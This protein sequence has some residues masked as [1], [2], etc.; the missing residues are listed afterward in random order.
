MHAAMLPRSNTRH[1]SGTR[2]AVHTL[3]AASNPLSGACRLRTGTHRGSTASRPS[4]KEAP[5]AAPTASEGTL[6]RQAS[7]GG[8]RTP[9]AAASP[10]AL[11][12][13]GGGNARAHQ[14]SASCAREQ[15][16]S[17]AMG[18][19]ASTLSRFAWTSFFSRRPLYISSAR[20]LRRTRAHAAVSRSPKC[21]RT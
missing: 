8:A 18:F 20:R 9:R 3:R 16:R 2:A 1:S 11:R 17:C 4:P 10:G 12:Q 14:A 5:Q 6:G 13:G 21:G 7:L 15:P 19:S